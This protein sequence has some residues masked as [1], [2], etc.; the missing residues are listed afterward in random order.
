VRELA[1]IAVICW[2]VGYELGFA[3]FGVLQGGPLRVELLLT[4][5]FALRQ[6]QILV[7]VLVGALLAWIR[8]R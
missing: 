8:A 1:A 3:F 4:P 2:A 7:G 6:V 5:L